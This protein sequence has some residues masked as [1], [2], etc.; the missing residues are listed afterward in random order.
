M[1]LA[2]ALL[3]P[4]KK[5][6]RKGRHTMSKETKKPTQEELLKACADVLDE[7]LAEYEQLQK[8][9]MAV[10][11]IPSKPE[12]MANAEVIADPT[13]SAPAGLPTPA[14]QA[15]A[16]P[17]ETVAAPMSA[18]EKSAAPVAKDEDAKEEVK[19]EGSD[20][21]ESEE[22]KAKKKKEEEEKEKGGKEGEEKEEGS[23]EEMMEHFKSL[24]AKLESKGLLK[25]GELIEA[26]KGE[27]FRKSVDER[28]E[29]LTASLGEVTDVIKR[30]ASAPMPRRGV[31]GYAPLK[32]TE[33][34]ESAPLHKGEV[35]NKLL[36]LRK[37]GERSID[38]ALI[39]RV[40]TNRLIKGDLDRI[41][42]LGILG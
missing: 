12:G 34:S 21:E 41:K 33:G 18:K 16:A 10:Q 37:G 27:D 19:E 36:N 8:A 20:E 40:E 7:A 29:K 23:D 11:E 4:N 1:T 25:K 15:G 26:D 42:N 14:A 22:E 30:L 3:G 24:S 6:E 13:K 9:S 38:T 28:F 2:W 31:A 39:N 35:V 32:K 17:G 5:V